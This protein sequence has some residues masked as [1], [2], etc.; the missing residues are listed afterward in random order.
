MS[1]IAAGDV[2]Q[3]DGPCTI[4]QTSGAPREPWTTTPWVS[5][6]HAMH[7]SARISGRNTFSPATRI[8]LPMCTL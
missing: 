4:T 2:A 3:G 7:G 1:S 8:T 6:R 5:G